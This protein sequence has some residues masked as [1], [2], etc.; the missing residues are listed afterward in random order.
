MMNILERK[1]I[2]LRPHVLAPDFYLFAIMLVTGF[3]MIVLFTAVFGRIWCGWLCP[4]TVLME[5]VFRKIEYW[6]EGDARSAK[7]L[8]DAPW[9]A[10]KICARKP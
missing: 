7:P 4:Q 5:M 1:F 6:I 2:G 10:G 3:M 8:H 9:T